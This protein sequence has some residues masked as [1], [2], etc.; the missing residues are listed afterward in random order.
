VIPFALAAIGM[1]AIAPS[2]DANT[3]AL[4]SGCKANITPGAEFGWYPAWPGS[5][6]FLR[7]ACIF[8]H[9]NS[10]GAGSS[11]ISSTFTIHDA[12]NIQY[13]NGAARRVK[14]SVA[15]GVGA[16]TITLD[17]AL[18]A[19]G[20]GCVGDQAFVN[21]TI[22]SATTGLQARS[23]VKTIA[24]CTLTLNQATTGAMPIGTVFF[25]D[26][27]PARSVTDAALSATNTMTSA[28]GNL[29]PSDVNL[30]VTGTEICDGTIITAV[31]AG[32]ATLSNTN[33]ACDLTS[34]PTGPPYAAQTITIGGTL[35]S[36]TTVAP[37]V[38]G[39]TT[40][41]EVNDTASTSTTRITSPSAKFQASDVGLRVSGAG[42]TSPN[43]IIVTRVNGT[44]IDVSTTNAPTLTGC[45]TISVGPNIITVGDPSFT[46]PAN[47]DT[48]LSQAA[49]LPLKPTLVA[50]SAPCANDDA[51]G[52]A[53]EGTWHN[54]GSFVAAT[55]QP[56]E[57]TLAAP[58][59]GATGTKAIGQ[60]VFATSVLSY[61][62]YVVEYPSG[63]QGGTDPVNGDPHYNIVFPFVPTGL[64]L[65]A[66]TPTSPGLGFSIG[67]QGASASQAAIPQG[68]GR[69]A[70]AQLRATRASTS[71][72][73]TTG[74]ITDDV[75]NG[76]TKWAFPNPAFNR[77]CIIPATTPDINF[78]CGDG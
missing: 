22:S 16:T 60:I 31:A 49:Q 5:Q 69:P 14:N 23:F 11:Q 78:V 71:G 70:T 72:S 44:T 25:I 32:V 21:R 61:S 58:L 17:A 30:S 52:F 56:G 50:G 55:P 34:P 3:P 29:L 73:T 18:T 47:G 10:G 37:T 64:A 12:S 45:T 48:V 24:G 7:V 38:G 19:D 26:N 28:S 77:T 67:V 63:L 33:G 57:H 74:V 68:M 59:A 20:N 13:H 75:Q 54:P 2:A 65:C 4:V 8:Q 41:R 27:S 1:L 46:A 15:V 53:L 43:C 51:A 76:G 9:A 6:S 40:S 66:S 36:T 39:V 42:I 35:D 62:A